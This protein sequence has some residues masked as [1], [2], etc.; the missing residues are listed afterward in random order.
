MTTKQ[1]S[2][3][4]GC[5][6][7]FGI[8]IG[9]CSSIL[10]FWSILT[11]MGDGIIH[12]EI[13]DCTHVIDQNQASE[14]TLAMACLYMEDLAQSFIQ[15]HETISGAGLKMHSSSG[16]GAITI[17]LWDKL[18]NQSG[19]ILLAT[20]SGTVTAPGWLDLFWE[21]VANSPGHTYYLVFYGNAS[22]CISGSTANPYSSGQVYAMEGYIPFPN[23]DF[24]FRTYYCDDSGDTPTPQPATNTPVPPTITP[25]PVTP[26]VPPTSATATSTTPPTQTPTTPN[27]SATPSST[28]VPPTATPVEPTATPVHDC[29]TLGCKIVMPRSDFAEGDLCYCDVAICNTAATT[30]EK[31]PVFV[32]LDVF[33]SMYFAPLFDDYSY[34]VLD[35]EPGLHTMRVLEEFPWPSGVG[36]AEGIRWYAAMTDFEVTKLYGDYAVFSF[37][38]H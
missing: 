17:E 29:E 30:I 15:T 6:R 11:V 3:G 37:G 28:S 27:P 32:I 25:T 5:M 9:I 16:T 20:A 21:P 2:L 23:A 8:S 18:P 19:A 36:K 4:K 14:E 1:Q 26:T 13:L 10:F 31:V 35:I 7:S 22:I 33:G 12:A 38:W 24:T 34:Y